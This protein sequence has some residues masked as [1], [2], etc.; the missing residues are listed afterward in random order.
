MQLSVA[1]YPIH[2]QRF[3]ARA[4]GSGSGKGKSRLPE[5]TESLL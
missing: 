2:I 5:K 1:K 4:Q 3:R